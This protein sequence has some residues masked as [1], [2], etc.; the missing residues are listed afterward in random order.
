MHESANLPNARLNT[1]R[2]ALCELLAIRVITH[3]AKPT[4]IEPHP[5]ASS[6]S[7]PGAGYGSSLTSTTHAYG[8]GSHGV[9]TSPAGDHA[10]DR[11]RR[12]SSSAKS[13]A[14]YGARQRRMS[15][16]E[17]PSA[18]LAKKRAD[19]LVLAN[20]LIAG[21][22]P[23]AGAAEEVKQEEEMEGRT[24][25]GRA[26]NALELAIVTEAKRFIAVSKAITQ[27]SCDPVS[28]GGEGVFE[29]VKE[30][31]TRCLASEDD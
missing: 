23:F 6:A 21:F 19:E 14:V 28:R 9:S 8:T 10:G 12:L 4:T 11:H 30:L 22:H 15:M 26:C 3:Y 1:S 5:G 16:A 25:L 18:R 27:E 7:L 24:E 2:A 17:P 20:V 31:E 29:S 13:A